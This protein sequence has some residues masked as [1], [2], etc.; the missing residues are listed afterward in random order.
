MLSH[1]FN[2]V[3]IAFVMT[4]TSYGGSLDFVD[5]DLKSQGRGIFLERFDPNLKNVDDSLPP[6]VPIPIPDGVPNSDAV[7]MPDE[8][9][10]DEMHKARDLQPIPEKNL[11]QLK[12]IFEDYFKP[13]LPKM[14][15]YFPSLE[16]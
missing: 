11:Y 8:C 9:R 4:G 16:R 7:P 1:T 3:V 2:R 10:G 5:A 15:S 14:R 6:G 12:K 13:A